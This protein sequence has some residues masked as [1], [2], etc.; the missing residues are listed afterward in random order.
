MEIFGYCSKMKEGEP[1]DFVTT[2]E[3]LEE[4]Q[5]KF[6]FAKY[7]EVD[8]DKFNSYKK[9]NQESLEKTVGLEADG[10]LKES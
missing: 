9:F 2:P 5:E 6:N 7:K 3:W 10:K 1:E 8:E 4:Q